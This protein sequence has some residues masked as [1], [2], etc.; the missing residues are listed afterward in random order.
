MDSNQKHTIHHQ[1][2]QAHYSTIGYLY[3]CFV[4]RLQPAQ[5]V[6]HGESADTSLLA[7]PTLHGFRGSPPHLCARAHGGLAMRQLHG[8]K[9]LPYPK[10]T[11]SFNLLKQTTQFFKTLGGCFMSIPQKLSWCLSK[12]LYTSVKWDHGGPSKKTTQFGGFWP[13]FAASP[14]ATSTKLWR[15]PHWNS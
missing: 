10:W 11:P 5:K 9:P 7:H 12:R 14:L 1:K 4:D 15:A 2:Q 6:N 8:S 13:S 3:N